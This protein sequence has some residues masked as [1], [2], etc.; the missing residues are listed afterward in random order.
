MNI[1]K[2]EQILMI[3]ASEIQRYLI[4][5]GANPADAQDIV[6]DVL[7]KLIQ[8]DIVLAPDKLRPWLYRVALSRFYDLYRRE[9][10]YQAL[11]SERFY[12]I[13]GNDDHFPEDEKWLLALALETLT[14]Y[15]LSLVTL[16]YENDKSVKEIAQIYQFSESK[17]K[18]DLYR[19]WQKLKQEMEKYHDNN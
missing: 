7:V 5:T 15:Q 13:Y 9:K 12:L 4:K 19:T 3:Y 18:T 6:Q 2:Y 10:R 14:D 11:L 8:A 1:S 16:Y 17:I